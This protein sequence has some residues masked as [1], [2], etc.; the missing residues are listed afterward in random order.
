MKEIDDPGVRERL[1]TWEANTPERLAI[2]NYFLVYPEEAAAMSGDVWRGISDREDKEAVLLAIGQVLTPGELENFNKLYQEK[3]VLR[4]QM[5][6]EGIVSG[7]Y[8]ASSFLS[9]MSS[10]F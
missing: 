1:T 3:T 8:G 5:I 6:D 10:L 2:K 9:E 7:D 4:R